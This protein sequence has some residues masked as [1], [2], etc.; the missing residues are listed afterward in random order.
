MEVLLSSYFPGKRPLKWHMKV[1]ENV[2]LGR[3]IHALKITNQ[4]E[5]LSICKTFPNKRK[6]K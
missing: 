3:E 2:V 5:L 6:R 4:E 1:C